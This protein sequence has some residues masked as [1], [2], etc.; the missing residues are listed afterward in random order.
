M[1]Q[2]MNLRIE[3]RRRWWVAFRRVVGDCTTP[4]LAII[5]LTLF[6]RWQFCFLFVDA[7]C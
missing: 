7:G 4:K 6:G 2:R 1:G 5:L 3:T